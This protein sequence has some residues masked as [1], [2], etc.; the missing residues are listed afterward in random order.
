M[1]KI[2]LL[3]ASKSNKKTYDKIKERLQGTAFDLRI[4]S[5]HKT[6]KELEDFLL[7]HSQEYSCIIAGA[8][9]AAHLAGVIAAKTTLPVIGVPCADNLEGLDSLLSTLQM[10]PGIPV[11]TTGVEC[12]QEAA[13]NA[14]KI[15][16]LK[17]EQVTI[18][19]KT[20]HAEKAADMLRKL[21]IKYEFSYSMTDDPL[22][23]RFVELDEIAQTQK[24]KGICIY[25]PVALKTSSKDS[26]KLL[27]IKNGLWVGINRAENA[28]IAAAQI[29]GSQG[30][31]E[32]RKE[33]ARQVLE[34]NENESRDI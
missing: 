25:C 13:E 24:K 1:K 10:P 14:Q 6:P 4:Y 3:F 33:F 2:L 22:I 23:I 8:G 30:I 15:A 5:A 9:L 29:L 12:T 28:A 27:E 16:N 31:Q 11:L 26:L 19:I 17:V 18:V 32:I 34:A 20:G 7:E 21:G